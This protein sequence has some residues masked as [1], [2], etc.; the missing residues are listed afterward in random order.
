VTMSSALAERFL[1][2]AEDYQQIAEQLE[3][4]SFLG[5]LYR[6]AD[7]KTKIC[8]LLYLEPREWSTTEISRTVR[9]SAGNVTVRLKRLQR[10]GLVVRVSRGK[11]RISTF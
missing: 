3:S 1:K 11:W 2:L 7:L 9:T 4:R 10:E 6:V 8:L 5:K